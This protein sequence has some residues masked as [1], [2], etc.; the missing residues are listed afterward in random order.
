[1]SKKCSKCKKEFSL[2]W[3]WQHTCYVCHKKFCD[4]CSEKRT[5]IPA[6]MRQN[7]FSTKETC[8]DCFPKIQRQINNSDLKSRYN[9]YLAGRSAGNQEGYDRGYGKGYDRGYGDRDDGRDPN[10]WGW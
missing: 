1:M 6:L 5:P 8:V 7:N 2:Y 3:T 9:A 10:K 4:K